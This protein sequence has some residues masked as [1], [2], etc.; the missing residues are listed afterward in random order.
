MTCL[1]Q[2]GHGLSFFFFES[3]EYAGPIFLLLKML[4]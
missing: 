3:D 4:R 2:L 1:T